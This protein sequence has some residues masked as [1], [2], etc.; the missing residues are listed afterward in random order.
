MEVGDGQKEKVDTKDYDQLM[1]AQ[2]AEAIEPFSSHIVPVKI[3][4]V[5]MG[6]HINVMVQAL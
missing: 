4:R 2:N 3:G 5:F 1:Y 6:E